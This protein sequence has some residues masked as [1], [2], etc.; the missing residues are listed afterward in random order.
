MAILFM[1][2]SL[3]LQESHDENPAISHWITYEV[4]WIALEGFGAADI[5]KRQISFRIQIIFEE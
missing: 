4:G 1:F 5:S 3:Y 2:A